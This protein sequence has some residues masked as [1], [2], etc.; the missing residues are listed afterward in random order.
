MSPIMGRRQAKEATAVAGL[1]LVV[2]EAPGKLRAM[3]TA[4]AKLGVRAEVT[5][6]LGHVYVN[7]RS[8]RPVAI[9]RDGAGDLLETGR[10]VA[11]PNVLA[12]VVAG[13]GRC[14][15]LVIAT[16]DD[17]EGHVI[18]QDLLGVARKVRP[19]LPVVRMRT[20]GLDLASVRD[21]WATLGAAGPEDAM[22][23]TARRLA[24][25][26]IGAAYT[27]FGLGVVVGRVQSAVLGLC[28][29]G[30]VRR[31]EAKITLP[32][33]DGGAPFHLT[34]DLPA[35]MSPEDVLA[36]ST[37][38][39]PVAVADVVD[40]PR[41]APMNGGDALLALESDLG[42]TIDAAADLL[43]DLY[44]AGKLSYPRS[45]SRGMSAGSAAQVERLAAIKGLLAFKRDAMP[46]HRLDDGPHEAIRV[47]STDV[48]LIKPP[49]M[50]GTMQE[51]AEAVLARRMIE[52]GVPG[53][54]EIGNAQA[55]PAWARSGLLVRDSYPRLPW[56][57]PAAT[58]PLQIRERSPE[59]ALVA[60]MMK[61]GVGR[62]STW[63]GH[64]SGLVKRGLV[65]AQL[66]LTPAGQASL[67][68]APPALREVPTSLAFEDAIQGSG[69][70][71]A[72]VE[73]ALDLA[74]AQTALALVVRADEAA[75]DSD[76]AGVPEP[77]APPAPAPSM[78]EEETDEYV[79][80]F[81]R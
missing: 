3:R 73:A 70:V 55:L 79:Y 69:P 33:A 14:A 63:A 53:R 57:R 66:Q 22:P 12:Q 62:P 54:R 72:R 75:R 25:R 16:D 43:Q 6:T 10:R 31:R 71:T 74:D 46:Q 24:D 7:S 4:L 45:A 11:K 42:L 35:K 20:T 34:V 21:A 76:P 65:D 80:R 41:V 8:L 36:A 68:A 15:R 17:Q 51:A 64:A 32:A 19:D 38:W 44:E 48:N 52:A 1:D 23:G 81:G 28:W 26:L 13:I 56:S 61:A 58:S 47:L 60:A 50:R 27:D 59:A 40:T 39:P 2:I 67:D 77:D 18:A 30:E 37:Q 29:A 9:E 78:I 5:A 49:R